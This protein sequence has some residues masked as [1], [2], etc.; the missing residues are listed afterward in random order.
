V[1][2]TLYL[3]RN[4]T[5]EWSRDGRV[6]GRRDLGL[7]AEGRAQAEELAK[8]MAE[9]EVAEVLASPLLHAVETAQPLAAQHG[10]EVARDPRLTDLAAG[11]WEGMRYA[12]IAAA[13]EYRRFLADPLA[14]AIPGGE[15]LTDTRDRVVASVAQ[16]LADNELGANL[17]VVSHAGPLRV[18][19]AHYL[20]MDLANY[21]RL[22]VAPASISVLRFESEFGV[23]RVLAI[24]CGSLRAAIR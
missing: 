1:H 19:L 12:D 16:A 15:R 9:V 23:P 18:L 13:E 8:R 4:A 22:R 3:I 14:Q 11:V 24:N 7:S 10:I 2:I 5:T 20:G 21:H 17:V 6:A